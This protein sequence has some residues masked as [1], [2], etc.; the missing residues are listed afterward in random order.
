MGCRSHSSNVCLIVLVRLP[1]NVDTLKT[2]RQVEQIHNTKLT[3]DDVLGVNLPPDPGRRRTR[4][5]R[6]WMQTETVFVMM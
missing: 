5:L 3:L 1:H 2:Q 6:A 4:Q